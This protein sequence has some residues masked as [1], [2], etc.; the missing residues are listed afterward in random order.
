MTCINLIPTSRLI[1]KRRRMRMRSWT[2]V[3]I[4]YA[5]ALTLT[6]GVVHA[7][8]ARDDRSLSTQLSALA[9]ETAK[10]EATAKSL[11]TELKQ[12][13][14]QW[15]SSHAVGRQPDWSMLLTILAHD[16]GADIVL[17]QLDLQP[18]APQPAVSAPAPTLNPGA[19]SKPPQD[20]AEPDQFV[21]RFNGYGQTQTAVSQFVLRLENIGLFSQ[22][23]LVETR[24]EPFLDSEA[25]AF[26][27]ECF[28]SASKEA[29]T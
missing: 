15:E 9:N 7:L 4:G 14:L 23:K 18:V 5:G 3:V 6:F 22:V 16:I 1:A 27:I 24:R 12:A 21:L 2:T 17:R 25:I 10:S 19:P 13:Q 8:A 29:G 20:V 11:R 26:R 28:I